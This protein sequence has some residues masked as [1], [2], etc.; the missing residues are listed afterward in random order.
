MP[1]QEKQALTL[2][3]RILRSK[4][5][6]LLQ[7]EPDKDEGQAGEEKLLEARGAFVLDAYNYFVKVKLT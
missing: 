2:M 6:E 1:P 7:Q 5:D 4:A 3:R